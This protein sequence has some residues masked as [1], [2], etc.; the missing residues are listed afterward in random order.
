M[1][2]EVKFSMLKTNERKRVRRLLVR[3][4]TQ[5]S[6]MEVVN[7][8]VAAASLRNSDNGHKNGKRTRPPETKRRSIAY[9][10]C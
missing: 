3:A 8:I 5:P 6:A 7:N 9:G 10:R 1:I 4:E 2:G